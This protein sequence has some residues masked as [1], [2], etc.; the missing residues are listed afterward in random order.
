VVCTGFRT[1]NGI[2]MFLNDRF[3]RAMD[4]TEQIHEFEFVDVEE[5][6][7]T[8]LQRRDHEER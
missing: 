4:L 7:I 3:S 6:L 1:Q 8:Q 5:A 2:G